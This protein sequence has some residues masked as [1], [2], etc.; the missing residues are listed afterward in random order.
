MRLTPPTHRHLP[1]RLKKQSKAI[2]YTRGCSPGRVE[3]HIAHGL[4]VT[5]RVTPRRRLPIWFL[6]AAPTI[7]RLLVDSIIR[8]A[9][10]HQFFLLPV[11]IAVTA[12]AEYL[13]VALQ[14]SAEKAA[15][16]SM[17]GS[18]SSVGGAVSVSASSVEGGTC[19]HSFQCCLLAQPPPEPLTISSHCNHR[20]STLRCNSETAQE[21]RA[22]HAQV[23]G[24][25]AA[26]QSPARLSPRS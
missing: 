23:K 15:S 4:R 9:F 20:Q 6:L 12:V 8:S 7:V 14:R 21:K 1:L 19:C 13:S 5:L 18:A 16:V 17:G 3:W 11:H 10:F 24:G 22:I 2:K 26:N 25:R